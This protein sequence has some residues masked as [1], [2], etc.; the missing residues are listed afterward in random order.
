MRSSHDKGSDGLIGPDISIACYG[1]EQKQFRNFKKKISD[2]Y[3]KY[4]KNWKPSHPKWLVYINRDPSP[5]ETNLVITLHPGGQLWGTRRIIEMVR[6][7]PWHKK[8]G[9]YKH[10]RIDESLIGQDFLIPILED[11][12]ANRVS[13][14][15]VDYRKKAPDIA[16]KIRANYSEQEIQD[17]IRLVELTF[18]QQATA[19]EALRAYGDTELN[20][21]KAKI[22]LDFTQTSSTSSFKDRV[23]TLFQIYKSKYNRG[24]DDGLDLYIKGLILVVFSQCLLGVEP[25]GE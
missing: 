3:A 7:L 20:R 17:E 5:D 8:L 24:N 9:L 15:S 12:V 18:D 11:L 21:I 10:L 4:D 22:L 16:A 2:D 23:C 25:L 6:E 1:P 13:A 19:E 14:N